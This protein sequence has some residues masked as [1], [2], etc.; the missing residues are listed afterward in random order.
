MRW[1]TLWA[2]VTLRSAVLHAMRCRQVSCCLH[3]P[4]FQPQEEFLAE[5]VLLRRKFTDEAGGGWAAA[6][7]EEPAEGLLNAASHIVPAPSAFATSLD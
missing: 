2:L 7:K 3:P 6:C 1:C 5:T 4:A